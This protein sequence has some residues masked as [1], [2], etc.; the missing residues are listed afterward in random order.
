[1]CIQLTIIIPGLADTRRVPVCKSR[2][3]CPCDGMGSD[4]IGPASP[5][6]TRI[7]GGDA[8]Y[9]QFGPGH[10][11]ELHQQ[12]QDVSRCM[13]SGV[14]TRATNSAYGPSSKPSY[15]WWS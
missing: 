1:M 15:S 11:R 5:C 13:R 2:R 12:R 9:R 7:E 4:F 10:L 3:D 6:A 14:I 8:I